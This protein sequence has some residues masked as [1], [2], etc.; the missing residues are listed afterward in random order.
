VLDGWLTDAHP[1]LRKVFADLV[2]PG[3]LM[4]NRQGAR[5]R[6]VQRLGGDLDGMVGSG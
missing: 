6:F 5:D 1:Q 2:N 3:V 4:Q